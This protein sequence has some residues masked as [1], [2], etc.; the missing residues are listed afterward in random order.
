MKNSLP[1]INEKCIQTESKILNDNVHKQ[2][3]VCMCKMSVYQTCQPL[4]KE[5]LETHEQ[6]SGD[7]AKNSE[8][9]LFFPDQ[10][11]FPSRELGTSL[12][13]RAYSPLKM[14][15]RRGEKR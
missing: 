15:D 1:L 2:I 3:C 9:L 13:P 14:A 12:I 7:S 10:T 11:P 5:N 4:V 6:K 8:I